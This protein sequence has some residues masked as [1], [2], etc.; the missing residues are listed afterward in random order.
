M[1]GSSEVLLVKRRYPPSAGWWSLPG[2]HVEPGEPLT[3][4][5]LRELREE[6]GLQGNNPKPLAI[7]EYIAWDKGS[8]K[9]HYL[10]VDFLIGSFKGEVRPNHE[11]LDIGFF[12]FKEALNMKITI[13]TRKLLYKII[14]GGVGRVYYLST[15]LDVGSYREVIEELIKKAPRIRERHLR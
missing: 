7:T 12:S 15:V 14:E 2:G 5:V 1:R 6:T 9:Y 3:D 4:A 10:I 13:T 8:L 11:S